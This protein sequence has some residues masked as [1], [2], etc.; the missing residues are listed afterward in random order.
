[1][2]SFSPSQGN[3]IADEGEE[4][5]PNKVL[6]I[7]L[8]MDSFGRLLQRYYENNPRV[9]PW[10][11]DP[12]PYHVWISEIMLQQTRVETVKGYY[13]RFM[14]ALPSVFDLAN[15]SEEVLLKLWE[16]L[17]YYSRARNILKAARIIVERYGGELPSSR[18]K[19]AELPGI[20]PYVSAAIASIAFH[21]KEVALD[22]NLVRIYARL[23]AED[24]DIKT[25]S[26]RKKMEDV[27]RSL[28][29]IDPSIF[30]QG[31]MDIGQTICLPNGAPLCSECPFK[32]LC[33]AHLLGRENDFPSPRK[34]TPKKREE[35]TIVLLYSGDR[36]FLQKRPSHGLLASLYEPINLSGHLSEEEVR[37]FL[38]NSGYVLASF[39]EIGHAEH[40][41]SHKIWDMV[42]Y[43]A[44]LKGQTDNSSF[45][46]ME[47]RK[48]RIS[49]PSAFSYFL[50]E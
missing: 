48:Q 15:A 49:I 2:R 35:R 18:E 23:Y 21:Q 34:P 36:L 19:L 17:G 37:E 30:N 27:Y 45:I 32:G 14:D 10:R 9:L 39:E 3:F 41:F 11:V 12:T 16:G 5:P 4:K 26:L 20:G 46:S 29:D 25:A 13:L 50:G 6:L 1:M 42:G 31:L 8:F 44:I 24:V 40:V 33:K 43:R 47:D 7:M 38:M 28:M 22:G